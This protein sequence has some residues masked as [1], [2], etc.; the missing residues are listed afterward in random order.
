MKMTFIQENP[1]WTNF[2]AD[3]KVLGFNIDKNAIEQY[4]YDTL[5]LNIIE[6]TLGHSTSQVGYT[7]SAWGNGAK[8]T[9]L[10]IFCL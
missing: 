9:L 8:G 3:M 5:N 7:P 2:I 6:V 4:S 10:P 1:S